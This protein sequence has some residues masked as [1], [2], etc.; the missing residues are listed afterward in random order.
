[1][2]E[3]ELDD[4]EETQQCLGHFKLA[5]NSIMKPLTLYGQS[6]YV[7]MAVVEIEQLAWQLHWKLLGIDV[8]FEWSD[9][10]W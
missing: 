8:P 4:E 3:I 5:L 6:E 2:E 9:L 10:H 1:M 7:S